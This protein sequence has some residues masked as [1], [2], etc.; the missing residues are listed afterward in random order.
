MITDDL[1]NELYKISKKESN[2]LEKLS[3]SEFFNIR[4]KKNYIY[5]H[6]TLYIIYMYIYLINLF[7]GLVYS[8]STQ[9]R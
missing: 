1:V 7:Q 8:M 5:V 3:M 2:G 9:S 6:I 4:I